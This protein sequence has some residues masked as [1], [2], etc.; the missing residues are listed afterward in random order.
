VGAC[1]RAFMRACMCARA[2]SRWWYGWVKRAA[3]SARDT[4]AYQQ[5]QLTKQRFTELTKQRF[6][7]LTKQRFTEL[8]THTHAYQQQSLDIILRHRVYL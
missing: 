3:K 4:H 8:N 1:V 7:E 6:T 2:R 5:E